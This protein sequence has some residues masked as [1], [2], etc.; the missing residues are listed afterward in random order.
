VECFYERATRTC[1]NIPSLACV[2]D[3]DCDGG[4]CVL[5]R[6]FNDFTLNLAPGQPFGWGAR[7]GNDVQGSGSGAAPPV[8]DLPFTGSLRCV[9]LDAQ[10]G[11]PAAGALEGVATVARRNGQT[12]E[13]DVA[14]YNA[15]GFAFLGS[16]GDRVLDLGGPEPEYDG[17]PNIWVL[18]HALDGATDPIDGTTLHPSFVLLPCAVNFELDTVTTNVVVHINVYNELG[19]RLGTSTTLTV[20]RTDPAVAI[21]PAIFDASFHGTLTA[22]TRIQAVGGGVI[23]GV[24]ERHDA[25]GGNYS[26]SLIRDPVHQGLRDSADQIVLPP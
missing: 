9:A 15:V 17:C 3:I 23:A 11:L 21:H 18:H 16:N 10:T 7:N 8:A 22:Q 20:H 1:S 24:R 25:G 2:E 5:G 4:T 14:K 12:Q 6:Q 26:P 19:Q 13:L